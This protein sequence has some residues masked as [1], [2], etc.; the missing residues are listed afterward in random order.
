MK[1]KYPIELLE[2]KAL[3]TRNNF[4]DISDTIDKLLEAYRNKDS[5]SLDEYE[6]EILEKMVIA[7]ELTYFFARIRP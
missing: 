1:K 3:E 7:D 2:E 4:K 5:Q 6:I